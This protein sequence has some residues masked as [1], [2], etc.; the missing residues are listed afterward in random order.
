M[1]FHRHRRMKRKRRSS[2]V[3]SALEPLYT[4]PSQGKVSVEPLLSGGEEVKEEPMEL[5]PVTSQSAPSTASPELDISLPDTAADPSD[6]YIF[7]KKKKVLLLHALGHSA[8]V[9]FLIKCLCW[10][11]FPVFVCVLFK[12][13]AEAGGD[14]DLSVTFKIGL[15]N[16]AYV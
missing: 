10:C 8:S 14:A 5:P 7:H 16:F 4:S 15:F 2:R 9:L 3:M 6:S 13:R 12:F 11:L 1:L